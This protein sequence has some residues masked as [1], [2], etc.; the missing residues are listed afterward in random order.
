MI[1]IGQEKG[2]FEVK[3]ASDC[4][5]SAKGCGLETRPRPES[6]GALLYSCL[7][8]SPNKWNKHLPRTGRWSEAKL[9]SLWYL[10]M[11]GMM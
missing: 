11:R 5:A 1:I 3:D 8:C 7:S 6:A 10:Q 2:H 4:E 9:M